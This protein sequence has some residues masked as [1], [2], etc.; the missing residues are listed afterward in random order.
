MPN[1][2]MRPELG[3]WVEATRPA[4]VAL[5]KREEENK[6]ITLQNMVNRAANKNKKIGM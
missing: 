4:R 6:A 5:A 1:P 2:T 3:A